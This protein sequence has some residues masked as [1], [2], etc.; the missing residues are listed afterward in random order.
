MI[1][2]DNLYTI[3][4]HNPESS[5]ATFRVKLNAESFIYQAHFPNNPITPGVCLIQMAVELF[6]SL[7]AVN[8]N[9][10]TLKNVKFTAPINPLEFPEADFLLKFAENETFW[11]LKVLIKEKEMVFAK[12]SMVLA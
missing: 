10:K 5:K 1:L 12:I 4:S 9:I 7:K 8:F 11:L 2:K 3:V 6:G